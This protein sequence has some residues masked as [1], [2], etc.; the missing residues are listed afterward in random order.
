MIRVFA[1]GDQAILLGTAE[2]P[3]PCP[4][5]GKHFDCGLQECSDIQNDRNFDY[6][7]PLVNG[8]LLD[9]YSKLGISEHE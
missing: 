5:L 8:S 1:V 2:H 9:L 4:Q 6:D 7:D 3:S